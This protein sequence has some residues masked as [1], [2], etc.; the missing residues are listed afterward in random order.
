MSEKVD[1]LPTR[2]KSQLG[3]KREISILNEKVK[4][5]IGKTRFYLM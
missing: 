1:N 3:Y 4:G 5:E 2:K